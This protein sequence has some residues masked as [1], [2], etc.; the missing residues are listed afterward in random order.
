MRRALPLSLPL[1][2][3]ASE[4]ASLDPSW[5]WSGKVPCLDG[6]RA[7]A[8]FAVLLSHFESHHIPKAIDDMGHYGVTLFF[9]ISG[10]LITLLLLRERRDTGKVSIRNFYHRRALRILPAYLVFLLGVAFLQMDGFVHLHM[11]DWIGALTYTSCF[12][13]PFRSSWALGHTWSL[14]VEEHF[15]LIWPFL[16]AKL[17]RRSLVRVLSGYLAFAVIL[18]WLIWRGYIHGFKLEFASPVQMSSIVMGC[19]LALVIAGDLA[20]K[21][22]SVLTKRP[23][24]L[25]A[26]PIFL[27]LPFH[28]L[29][30]NIKT[31]LSDPVHAMVFAILIAWILYR[32]KEGIVQ[33]CLN[34][35][36][37]ACIG[38]LSYS[39]YLWQQPLTDNMHIPESAKLIRLILLAIVASASYWFVEK[40]FL[41]HRKGLSRTVVRES[42]RVVF[43]APEGSPNRLLRSTPSSETA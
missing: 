21:A 18:R 41:R 32:K 6:L 26:V 35:K 4:A 37:L 14:S 30:K 7:V 2:P 29:S 28:F 27:T 15:Y 33:S 34:W 23:N 36:P 9:V 13:D 39:I 22:K 3:Q 42:N 43:E 5:V 16:F 25:L 1:E 38:I 11:S 40:P 10:F 12:G 8:I 20:P 17:S 19:I 24:I 31:P